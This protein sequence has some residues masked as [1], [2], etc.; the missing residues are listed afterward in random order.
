MVFHDATA[1]CVCRLGGH[2]GYLTD[3]EKET[4]ENSYMA[5]TQNWPEVIAEAEQQ[6]SVSGDFLKKYYNEYLHYPTLQ[7]RLRGIAEISDSRGR[8]SARGQREK[9]HM[10]VVVES[11][12]AVL[13]KVYRGDRLTPE[14]ALQLF[15]SDDLL[16][17]GMAADF[18]RKKLHPDGYVTY[19]VDRNINY[20][21]I[22]NV[23]CSFCAFYRAS[24]AK[25][26][27]PSWLRS[28]GSKDPGNAG[29][30]RHRHPDARRTAPGIE[31]RMVRSAASMHIK[32]KFP[33][34]WVHGFSPP[35]ITN[36]CRVSRLP[37]PVVMSR[38]VAAGL[39]SLAGRRR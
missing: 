4:L 2:R 25:R 6:I 35:E 36:I 1:V 21:N 33:A 12:S 30:E 22:C 11:S 9:G 7:E 18:V 13:D 23:E 39:D 3:A 20:T 37:L 29:F 5:G 34:I 26:F 16:E 24:A 31:D 32:E 38:L 28:T 19:I 27:V 15:H 10:D 17:L 14:D 8:I